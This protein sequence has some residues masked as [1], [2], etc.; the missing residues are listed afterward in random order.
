VY[1]AAS[2]YGVGVPEYD[3]QSGAQVGTITTGLYEPDGVAY[4]QPAPY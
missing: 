4:D 2:A 3:F 1:V